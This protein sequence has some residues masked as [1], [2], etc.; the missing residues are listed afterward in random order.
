MVCHDLPLIK[1][2]L[3]GVYYPYKESMLPYYR[4][5]IESAMCA[6][7]NTCEVENRVNLFSYD[8]KDYARVVNFYRIYF[9]ETYSEIFFNTVKLI[10]SKD[11]ELC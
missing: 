5:M 6:A 2:H 8:N 3:N 9:K 11:Y 7:E 4:V 10:N 1:F